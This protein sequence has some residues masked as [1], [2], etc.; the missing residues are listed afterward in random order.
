MTSCS[1][2]LSISLVKP[3]F[4]FSCELELDDF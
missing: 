3:G 1:D 4:Y 2:G